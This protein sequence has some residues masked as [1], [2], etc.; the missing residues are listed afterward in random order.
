MSAANHVGVCVSDLD[1]SIAFYEA[2]G[3]RRWWDLRVPD[4]ATVPLLALSPPLDLHAV[5]LVLGGLVL[6]LLHYG[7]GDHPSARSRAMDEPGLTHL[8]VSVD[9]LDATLEQVAALGGTVLPD[10]RVGIA[11]MVRDPDGQLLELTTMRWQGGLPP[12]PL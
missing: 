10:S 1:R 11:V 6:E 9:D 5:Y 7:A 12:P 8:S 2:L 4:A 3:F